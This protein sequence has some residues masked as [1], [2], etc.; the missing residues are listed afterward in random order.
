MNTHCEVRFHLLNGPNYMKWQVK[1]MSGKKKLS[2]YY[3]DPKQHN[4]ELRGC[5]LVNNL[6]RAKW[7]NKKQ[8]KNVS[9]WVKCQEVVVTSENSINTLE[10]LF[11]NPI[12]DVHWRREGDSG[13]FA[14]DDSEYET[15][16]TEGKQVYILEERT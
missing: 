14:W 13:E 11:Y 2:E 3:L 16:V 6:A 5:K 7:V 9:G 1:V 8:K 10:R 12:K 15:L 4:L